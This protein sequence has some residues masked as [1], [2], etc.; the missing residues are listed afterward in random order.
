MNVLVTGGNGFVGQHCCAL[1]K[2]LGFNVVAPTSAALDITQPFKLQEHFN[3]VIHLAAYNI[4]SVG[5]KNAA[6]YERVNVL[7]TRHVIEG[8]NC[9]QFIFLSTAKIY[10]Q[11]LSAY[12]KSKEAAEVLCRQYFKG[13][14]LVIIRSANVLGRGQ[15][16]KAVL[17]VFIAKAQQDQPLELTVNPRTPI[18]YIDVRDVVEV[19]A[20]AL[21][22]PQKSVVYN[23]AYPDIVTL[24]DLALKVIAA[25][26]SSSKINISAQ[27]GT[28]DPV[29][30]DC[31]K[32]WD[33]LGFTPRYN[34][35]HIL[36]NILS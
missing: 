25:C 3:A 29:L 27:A 28:I 20:R 11:H 19:I 18:T 21:Q 34:I 8:I 9:D 2:S 1:L 5:D 26:D 13:K 14:S 32:T 22:Y 12:A 10:D 23:A 36:E 17:P 7:G 24:Q 33:D 16:P 35:D 4:T 31:Q 6:M 15:A 30:I